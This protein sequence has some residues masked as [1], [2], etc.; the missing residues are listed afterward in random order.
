VIAELT[1]DTHRTEVEP[2]RTSGGGFWRITTPSLADWP[3]QG[4]M[5]RLV[6]GPGGERALETWMVD[7]AGGLDARDLAGAARQLSYDDAQGGRPQRLAGGRDDRNV[8]L[9][10]PPRR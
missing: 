5:L 9:W 6:T 8:R 3:Q 1:G 10:L 4:R 2:V 7:H